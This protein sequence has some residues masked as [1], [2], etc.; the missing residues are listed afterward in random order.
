MED[1]CRGYLRVHKANLYLGYLYIG[2][3]FCT[4]PLVIMWYIESTASGNSY[5]P[6]QRGLRGLDDDHYIRIT[7]QEVANRD[8]LVTQALEFNQSGPFSEVFL[9]GDK[10]GSETEEINC[11][12]CCQSFGADD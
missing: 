11:A 6:N 12:V 4:W 2:C 10:E 5:R 8:I 1:E 3:H 7:E 9:V